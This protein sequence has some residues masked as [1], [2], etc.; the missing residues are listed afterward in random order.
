MGSDA[1]DYY[2]ADT[3]VVT[4]HW[5]DLRKWYR[6][7]MVYMPHLY[8]VNSHNGVLGDDLGCYRD[9]YRRGE[10]RRMYRLPEEGFVF[11]CY[12]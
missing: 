6:E 1:I 11:C 7:K 4:S 9:G 3:T 12:S 5:R 2:I 10:G 8:F